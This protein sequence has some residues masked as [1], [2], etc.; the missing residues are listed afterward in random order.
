MKISE[1]GVHQIPIDGSPFMNIEERWPKFK[2]EP[3]NLRRSLAVDDV[4]P[5]G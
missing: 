1:D 5:F 4:N 3:C 2:E